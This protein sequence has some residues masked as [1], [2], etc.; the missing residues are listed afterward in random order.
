M[1]I[2]QTPIIKTNINDEINAAMGQPRYVK[3]MNK[4]KEFIQHIISSGRISENVRICNTGLLI[5]INRYNIEELLKN[6]YDKCIEHE[7]PECQIYWSIFSQ[8][9]KNEITEIEW[10]DIKNIKREIPL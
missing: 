3:N 6:V 10:N 7:Q 9:Y 5:Y 8:K 2:R 4:T 1:I